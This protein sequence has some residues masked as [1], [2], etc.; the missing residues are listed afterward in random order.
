[1]GEDEFHETPAQIDEK[2]FVTRPFAL[3]LHKVS[4]INASSAPDV[5]C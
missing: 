2:V 3:A 5:I 1:M 4:R